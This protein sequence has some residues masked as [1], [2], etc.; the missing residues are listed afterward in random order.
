MMRWPREICAC[1]FEKVAGSNPSSDS[2]ISYHMLTAPIHYILF[3]NSFE[4][5]VITLTKY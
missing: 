3:I 4:R 5:H 1:L 2:I